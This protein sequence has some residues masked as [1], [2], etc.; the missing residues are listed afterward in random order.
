[1]W[2]FECP[3]KLCLPL[4]KPTIPPVILPVFGCCSPD[5]SFWPDF[6][7]YIYPVFTFFP[8]NL[9]VSPLSTL[10]TPSTIPLYP[11]LRTGTRSYLRRLVIQPHLTQTNRPTKTPPKERY[12]VEYSLRPGE[13]P[14]M[15]SPNRYV[16]VPLS[17]PHHLYH[18]LTN[19]IAG[20]K[21]TTI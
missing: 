3:R 9:G 15:G 4:L 20:A 2:C 14:P 17:L 16:E 12:A 10:P 7:V 21:K 8:R 5:R 1:M 6:S 19:G 18:E 13:S 11:F